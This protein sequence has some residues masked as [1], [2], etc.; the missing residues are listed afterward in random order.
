MHSIQRGSDNMAKPVTDLGTF[1]PDN[2]IN[3]NVPV[4]DVVTVSLAASQGVLPRGA[5]ITGTAG[6]ALSQVKAALAATNA[7]YVL[8]DETDAT[9]ATTATAYRTGHFNTEALVTGSDYVL[10]AADKQV[11]RGQ[12][13]LVSDAIDYTPEPP[14]EADDDEES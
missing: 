13:I 2:L 3:S 8:T 11:L 10:T 7:V 12:G 6:S 14:A 5:L 1:T 9:A 4:A